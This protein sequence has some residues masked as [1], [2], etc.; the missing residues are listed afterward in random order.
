[1]DSVESVEKFLKQ[2]WAMIFDAWGE[3]LVSTR[4]EKVANRL[5]VGLGQIDQDW[6]AKRFSLEFFKFFD[7]FRG[8]CAF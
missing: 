1:M 5:T 2:G 4:S 6:G 8:I 7:Q 3:D